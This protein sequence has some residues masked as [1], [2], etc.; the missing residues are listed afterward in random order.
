MEILGRN[1]KK[2]GLPGKVNQ[3]LG[4]TDDPRYTGLDPID[5]L[6]NK[7]ETT[8]MEFVPVRLIVQE[9]V[10]IDDTHANSLAESMRGSRGQISP[11]TV[12]ARELEGSENIHYDIIDGFH[13]AQALMLIGSDNAKCVVVYGCG[14]EELFDLRVLAAN[15]V[16][17]VQF[18]RV[19]K[20][21]QNSF[22]NSEWFGRGLTL[23]Q[24]FG[25]VVSD[26]NRSNLG[27]SRDEVA[28]AKL[29]A[30]S[31]SKIWNRP[32]G[33]I[34][35]DIR[36]VEQAPPDIVSQVRIGQGT[37][38]GNRG[39]LT[40]ARLKSIVSYLGGEENFNLQRRVVS[41]VLAQNILAQEAGILAR[42]VDK[43]KNEPARLEEIFRDP[44][45]TI[46]LAL[47]ESIE[48]SDSRSPSTTK[49]HTNEAKVPP[50]ASPVADI[51][52][53]RNFSG[54]SDGEKKALVLVF[55][56]GLDL[57]EASSQLHMTPNQFFTLIQSGIRRYSLYL[58][59]LENL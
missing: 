15:S 48:H 4:L 20:W 1:D 18:A 53:W 13:R 52:W 35:L 9:A 2:S 5:L 41:V 39:A 16:R 47:K 23:S 30:A 59:N 21:M 50:P 38:G 22:Q 26:S 24:I 57:D 42:E 58:D 12:R 43:H 55:D 3:S 11:M 56:K 46:E 45:E 14:D 36:T 7:I 37:H 32:T 51:R 6:R 34:Y 29:W 44:R 31:K 25:L 17:S 28:R 49:K 54:L 40:P 33:S 27:L 10:I 8:R 19:A